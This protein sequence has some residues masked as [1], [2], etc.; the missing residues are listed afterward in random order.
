MKK[1]LFAI[2]ILLYSFCFVSA[3]NNNG[4]LKPEKIYLHTD[5]DKYIAGEYLFYTL[6]LQGNPGQLSK[7]AYLIIRDKNN[8]FVTNIRLEINDK[9]AFGS[10]YLS[11]TLNSGIYQIVCYTNSMRNYSEDF[12]FTKEI[13]IANRFDKKLNLFAD[14]LIIFTSDTSSNQNAGSLTR[15]ENLIF[16]LNKQVFDQREKIS[17][18]IESNNIPDDSIIRLSVSIS[19]I[20]MGM[21]NE[22]SISEYFNNNNLW[23][24][25]KN[26]NEI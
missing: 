22:P 5:R 25:E 23:E 4:S 17:F 2:F 18:S 10:I 13:V 19:E 26:Q 1:I 8:S 3:Q 11:D 24:K 12:Y 9:I 14:S 16:H 21:P 7:Y 20:V 15:N 6:Y